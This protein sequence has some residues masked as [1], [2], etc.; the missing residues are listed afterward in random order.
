M[1]FK[2]YFFI[3]IVFIY[4]IY[5]PYQYSKFDKDENIENILYYLFILDKERNNYFLIEEKIENH[6]SKCNR[7]SLCKKYNNYIKGKNEL[8]LYSIIS[9]CNNQIFNLLNKIV[10]G[11]KKN[12]KSSIINNSYYLINII[13]IY[14]LNLK[15]KSYCS[16]LNTELLLI[17][18]TNF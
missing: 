3:L 2:Y 4:N 9:N 7:C 12:G 18:R 10:I 8:D 17:Q 11:I 16:L 13:Y 1:L 15:N 6:I 14:H 5:D